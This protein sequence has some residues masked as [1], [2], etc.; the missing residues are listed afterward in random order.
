LD[1]GSADQAGD[2][3]FKKERLPH[4]HSIL[5]LELRQRRHSEKSREGIVF[6]RSDSMAVLPDTRLD[7]LGVALDDKGKGVSL[8][9]SA[10]HD[11]G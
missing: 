5:L 11:P 6:Y 3:T 4:G 2:V 9:W 8:M 7:L 1:S 10:E